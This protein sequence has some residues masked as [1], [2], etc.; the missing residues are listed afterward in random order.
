MHGLVV[1]KAKPKRLSTFERG[2]WHQYHINMNI[3]IL[4][5]AKVVKKQNDQKVVNHALKSHNQI[6]LL[7]ILTSIKY[8]NNFLKNKKSH[9]F[10]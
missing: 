7:Q 5:D 3:R 4:V 2:L 10:H 6:E 8:C 9:A 1:E